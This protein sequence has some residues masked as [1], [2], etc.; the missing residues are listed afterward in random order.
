MM[1]HIQVMGDSIQYRMPLV[2]MVSL[3]N[4]LDPVRANVFSVIFKTLKAE[5]VKVLSNTSIYAIRALIYMMNSE[6]NGPVSVGEMSA[7][8]KISFHFLTKIL[9]K[10]T[11]AGL[12]E[13][14]RGPAGGISFSKKPERIFL[15]DLVLI[16]EGEDFFDKCLLGLPGCGIM[17]PCPVHDFWKL[18]RGE[19]RKR[20]EGISI[21][22][23]KDSKG[24]IADL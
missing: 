3:K 8:L 11:R 17:A 13:S 7:R 6:T 21:Y 14:R 15:A 4:F 24:R 19:L 5:L 2:G 18:N 22:S 16:I 10:L 20:F 9:Q 1:T 12:L 23:L